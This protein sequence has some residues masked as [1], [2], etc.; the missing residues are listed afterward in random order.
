MTL[1]LSAGIRAMSS[2]GAHAVI[3]VRVD[4][5]EIGPLRVETRH[6]KKLVCLLNAA[7]AMQKAL[8]NLL[9][10]GGIDELRDKNYEHVLPELGIDH[11]DVKYVVMHFDRAAWKQAQA[12][13]AKAKPAT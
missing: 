12:A 9:R 13:H 7:G 5:C 4:D 8:G 2:T 11:Q 6:S 10:S 1:K 3:S